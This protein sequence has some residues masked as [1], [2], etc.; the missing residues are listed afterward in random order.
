MLY[1]Q[2]FIKHP[3]HAHEAICIC[4]W[5]FEHEWCRHAKECCMPYLN[6]LGIS[7]LILSFFSALE[8]L[9]LGF[10][11]HLL[12]FYLV[13]GDSFLFHLFLLPWTN[14]S[15]LGVGQGSE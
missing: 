6:V 7:I 12:F 1:W 9:E 11:F 3:Q 10:G 14:T 2:H 15:S 5:D 4:A 8:A 13:L